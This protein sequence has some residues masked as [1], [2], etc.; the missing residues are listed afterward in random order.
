MP[1]PTPPSNEQAFIA[2][3][4]NELIAAE[5]KGNQDRAKLIRSELKARDASETA[6]EVAPD[7]A[8]GN[9]VETTAESAPETTAA[10][11]RRRRS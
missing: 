11:P 9:P 1:E 2:A 6:D 10:K 3:L 4:R 5:A 8:D 7:T